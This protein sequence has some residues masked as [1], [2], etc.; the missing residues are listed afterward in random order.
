MADEERTQL[1]QC[2]T[3][4]KPIHDEDPYYATVD[5]CHL[6]PEHAP[7]LRD[8]V[9]Q[10]ERALEAD[11]ESYWWQL[12]FKTRAEFEMYVAGCKSELEATGD[13]KLI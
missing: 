5:G 4:D 11:D 12:D 2:E 9:N 7:T 6:C 3:C 1:W 13:R 10:Y 8:A